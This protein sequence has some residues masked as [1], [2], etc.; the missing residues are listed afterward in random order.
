MVELFMWG[1]IKEIEEGN[2]KEVVKLLRIE[3][4]SGVMIKNG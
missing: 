2:F 1:N 3:W 4:I